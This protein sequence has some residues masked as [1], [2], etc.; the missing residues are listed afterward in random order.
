MTV[1]R[2]DRRSGNIIT[3][4]ARTLENSGIGT[5]IR[6]LRVNFASLDSGFRFEVLCPR[7]ELLDGLPEDRFRIV[8][9][10]SSIYSLS[11]QWEIAHLGWSAGVFTRNR[12][13][14]STECTDR[15]LARSTW[16]VLST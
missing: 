14:R 11:E 12:F 1:S 13:I 8:P 9:K 3:V 6:N 4:D 7:G 5:Y 15:R 10:K 16:L 2:K